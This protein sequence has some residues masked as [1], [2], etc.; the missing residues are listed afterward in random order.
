MICKILI[1]EKFDSDCQQRTLVKRFKPYNNVWLWLFVWLLRLNMTG[2][3]GIKSTKERDS[4]N[5]T[6]AQFKSIRPASLILLLANYFS[7]IYIKRH[8]CVVYL[9]RTKFIAMAFLATF[10]ILPTMMVIS[11]IESYY[12]STS[13]DWMSNCYVVDWLN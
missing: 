13:I 5:F 6:A 10:L 9:K 12:V 8:Y 2:I 3:T 4:W 1:Q 7:L 11:T